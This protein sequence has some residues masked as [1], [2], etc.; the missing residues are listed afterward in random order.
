[1]N[2]IRPESPVTPQ[3][4]PYN[5]KHKPDKSP[6]LFYDGDQAYLEKN[7]DVTIKLPI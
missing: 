5:Q 2:D 6:R 4:E 7:G 1:M 3:P